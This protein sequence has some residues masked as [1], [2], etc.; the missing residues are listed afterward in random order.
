MHVRMYVRMK[1]GYV[2]MNVHVCMYAYEC[3]YQC[4]YV[5]TTL[6]MYTVQYVLMIICLSSDAHRQT[7]NLTAILLEPMG[8]TSC[9]VFCSSDQQTNSAE[10]RKNPPHRQNP[11]YLVPNRST[12]TRLLQP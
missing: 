4:M 1:E 10:D 8:R 2:C 7:V 12:N 6:Y 5:R 3:M 11:C 9:L